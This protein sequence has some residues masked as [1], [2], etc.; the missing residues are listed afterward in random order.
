MWHIVDPYWDRHGPIEGFLSKD[1]AMAWLRENWSNF[2]TD[3][4]F[5]FLREDGP[6][7]T[8]KVSIEEAKDQS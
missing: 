5:K 2:D 6:W 3:C 7:Y 8:F 4:R 1:T